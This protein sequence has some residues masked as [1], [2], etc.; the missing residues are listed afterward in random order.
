[1]KEH[2]LYPLSTVC[3]QFYYIN[4][5]PKHTEMWRVIDLFPFLPT[6]EHTVHE[7]SVC[8]GKKRIIFLR[9]LQF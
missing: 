5:V 8:Q 6:K 1:M 2:I 4:P 7:V 9:R 3:Q